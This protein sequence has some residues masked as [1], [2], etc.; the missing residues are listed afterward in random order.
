MLNKGL[1]C[2]W[3]SGCTC[4]FIYWR[5]TG[6]PVFYLLYLATFCGRDKVRKLLSRPL[7]C[8]L[9]EDTMERGRRL[10]DGWVIC[11]LGLHA[12]QCSCR[13]ISTFPGS[14]CVGSNPGSAASPLL[15]LSKFIHRVM[16]PFLHPWHWIG[17]DNYL[18]YIVFERIPSYNLCKMLDAMPG[19]H[20]M[21]LFTTVISRTLSST[22]E[23]LLT[24]LR[25]YLQHK[26][27]SPDPDSPVVGVVA[28]SLPLQQPK[29]LEETRPFW[30]NRGIRPCW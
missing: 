28:G 24:C 20:S 11:S 14:S 10:M 16:P 4:P 13:V 15:N 29:S 19:N 8:S 3:M 2:I 17:G 25:G 6:R 18:L 1:L 21:L 9:E 30:V 27:I 23:R 5:V 12:W 26:V 7:P 22:R